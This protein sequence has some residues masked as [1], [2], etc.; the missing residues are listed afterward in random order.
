MDKQT[1]RNRFEIDDFIRADLD[2]IASPKGIQ[3]DFR[4]GAPK[5]KA[6]IKIANLKIFCDY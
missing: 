5:A 2:Q 1:S 4:S 3:V 6:M